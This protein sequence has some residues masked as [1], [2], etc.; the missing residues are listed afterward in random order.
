MGLRRELQSGALLAL[1][2]TSSLLSNVW[3]E[4]RDGTFLAADSRS[5]GI[6]P[7]FRDPSLFVT[8][9]AFGKRAGNEL[10][11][12]NPL[13]RVIVVF[14]GLVVT[15]CSMKKS[16]SAEYLLG[17]S[18]QL[19]SRWPNGPRLP[20]CRAYLAVLLTEKRGKKKGEAPYHPHAPMNALA[21]QALALRPRVGVKT[22]RPRGLT[23]AAAAPSMSVK[24]LAKPVLSSHRRGASPM[25]I[26][27][28]SGGGGRHAAAVD[29]VQPG[30]GTVGLPTR[31]ELANARFMSAVGFL[32][33][34]GAL[35]FASIWAWEARTNRNF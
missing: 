30:K 28:I 4:L 11:A 18:P 9:E 23:V 26:A 33:G 25:Q 20:S 27:E 3:C 29:T 32:I 15:V 2:K 24:D 22:R 19:A 34:G 10:L 1:A 7:S 21:S 16:E 17:R 13:F 6:P 31:A 35:C 5:V 14:S 8:A 12:P